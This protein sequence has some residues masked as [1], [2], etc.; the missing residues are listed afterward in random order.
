[1]R[2]G[3]Q[4][5]NPAKWRTCRHAHV[6]VRAHL[7]RRVHPPPVV[8]GVAAAPST[9]AGANGPTDLAGASYMSNAGSANGLTTGSAP[10]RFAWGGRPSQYAFVSPRPK[11]T[12]CIGATLQRSWSRL[13][14]LRLDGRK[15]VP[16]AS[17][18]DGWVDGWRGE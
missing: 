16:D 11:F 13:A 17:R 3:S 14:S 5:P 10:G 9:A 4:Q 7:H 1:M 15:L 6:Y 12:G 18:G 2:K 8:R